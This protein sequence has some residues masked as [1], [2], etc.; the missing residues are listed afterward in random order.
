M[1]DEDRIEPQLA[2]AMRAFNTSAMNGIILIAARMRG[3]GLL[4]DE[5]VRSFH[6]QLSLPLTEQSVSDNAFIPPMQD[7]IDRVFAALLEMGKEP[8]VPKASRA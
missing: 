4:D 7:Y 3:A 6:E 8:R 5:H 2:V 1:N